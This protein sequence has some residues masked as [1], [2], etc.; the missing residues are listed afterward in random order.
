[1][2]TMVKSISL[3]YRRSLM[4]WDHVHYNSRLC[5]GIIVKYRGCFQA[6][7]MNRKLVWTSDVLI[8]T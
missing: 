3:V 7:N 2:M 8:M 4:F 1:M 6:Q 5:V